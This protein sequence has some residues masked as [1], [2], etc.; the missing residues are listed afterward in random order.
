MNQIFNADQ[1]ATLARKGDIALHDGKTVLV[2]LDGERFHGKLESYI[3]GASTVR[4]SVAGSY[5]KRDESGKWVEMDIIE[6][7]NPSFENYLGEGIT[8]LSVMD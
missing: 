1:L 6:V 7:T 4:L 2:T 3:D 8:G 5:L